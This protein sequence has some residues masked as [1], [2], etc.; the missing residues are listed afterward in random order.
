MFERECNRIWMRG[1]NLR[2]IDVRLKFGLKE[3]HF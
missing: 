3:E 2:K 1:V